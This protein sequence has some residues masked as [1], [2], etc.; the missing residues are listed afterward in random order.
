MRLAWVGI[1]S[2]LST[3]FQVLRAAIPDETPPSQSHS[4]VA[5]YVQSWLLLFTEPGP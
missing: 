5:G 2:T 3:I 4:F 1:K